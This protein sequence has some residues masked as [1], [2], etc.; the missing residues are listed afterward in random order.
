[1]HVDRRWLIPVGHH[2]LR[3]VGLT[4]TRRRT[5]GEQPRSDIGSAAGTKRYDKMDITLRP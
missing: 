5:L 2:G 1:M 4:P 3:C